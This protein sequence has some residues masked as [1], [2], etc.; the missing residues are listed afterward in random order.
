MNKKINKS[1]I[2]ADPFPRTMS[3]L[4]SRKNLNYLK[5]NFKIIEANKVN[6]KKFYNQNIEKA[7]FII[8]QPELPCEILLKAK[9]LKAIFNVESNFIDNMDY[10]YCFERGIHVLSTSPVFAQP[11][12]EMACSFKGWANS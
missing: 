5:S 1:V 9:K 11:V 12:A 2:I 7:D 3:L 4:F 6:K 8:G 10:N